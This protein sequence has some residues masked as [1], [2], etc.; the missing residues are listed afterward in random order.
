MITVYTFLFLLRGILEGMVSLQV[1]LVR[2]VTW[3]LANIFRH[4]GLV[5]KQQERQACVAALKTLLSHTDSEVIGVYLE[6]G[7]ER[8]DVKFAASVLFFFLLISGTFFSSLLG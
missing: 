7:R 1:S 3:V 2:V 5:M 4:K 6:E 8:Y